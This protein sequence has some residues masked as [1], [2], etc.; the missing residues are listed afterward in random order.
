M[1]ENWKI[2]PCKYWFF[3]TSQVRI[4]WGAQ[5]AHT[6]FFLPK[7]FK[8]SPKLAKKIRAPCAPSFF[9]FRIHPCFFAQIPTNKTLRKLSDSH[10]QPL[11]NLDH[12]F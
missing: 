1:I 12:V 9:K 3:N 2:T 8:K 6:H 7:F 5:G 10:K 4:Q 11:E